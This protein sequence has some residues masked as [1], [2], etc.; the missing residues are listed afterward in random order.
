MDKNI[1][2]NIK[3]GLEDAVAFT[4]GDKGRA[5]VMHVIEDVDVRAV[6]KKTGMT[7]IQFSETFYIPLPTLKNWER[8]TRKPE[9]PTR[10]YLTA[11]GN[12]P[13]EVQAALGHGFMAAE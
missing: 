6:R 1:F 13:K 5:R 3:A 4:K 2:E 10:A 7:Q 9:G 12:S 8:G 11:I